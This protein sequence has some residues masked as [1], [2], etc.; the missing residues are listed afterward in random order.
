MALPPGGGARTSPAPGGGPGCSQAVE[1]SA[2]VT[3]Q[4][5]HIGVA[6]VAISGS[7]GNNLFGLPS[8]QQQ[9]SDY[10]A[11]VDAINKSGGIQCRRLVASYYQG[12]PLDQSGEHSICLQAM[13]DHDFAVLDSEAL[14]NPP[15]NR[16]CLP[17]NGVPL[18]DVAPLGTNELAQFSPY[19]FTDNESYAETARNFVLGA[20]QRGWFPR[21]AKIGALEEDCVPELRSQFQ[22]DM[23]AAGIPASLIDVYDYGCPVDTVPPNQVE[24]AVLQFQSAGVTNVIGL[25][26]TATT[27]PN[28]SKLA[29]NQGYHPHYGMPDFG[30]VATTET[31]NNEPDRSNFDGALA[32][33]PTAYGAQNSGLPSSPATARCD[34]IL[35]TH[36]QPRLEDQ[37]VFYGGAA[38]NLVWTFEQAAIQDRGLSRQ[39]LSSGLERVGSFQFSF[40]GGPQDFGPAHP[41]TG[42]GYWRAVGFA[43]A[44]GCW[45]VLDPTFRPSFG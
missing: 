44:C 35:T 3:A 38:C 33:T 7:V 14:D 11:A 17:Q 21:G 27:L 37:G 4:D 2:G 12:N 22:A 40:P 5:I 16:D 1:P 45:K 8:P 20:R 6:V 25:E 10:A 31:A 24:Q 34:Q 23:A 43:G 32:V 41:D 42:G 39:G 19:L 13:Q 9:Q 26:T 36:G 30:A 28:F 29:Q 18:I 15:S